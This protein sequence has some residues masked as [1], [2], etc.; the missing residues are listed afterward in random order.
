MRGIAD[1]P[2]ITAE[3]I[4]GVSTSVLYV[5][6]GDGQVYALNALTGAVIWHT[7]VATVSGQSFLWSSPSVYNGSVYEGTSSPCDVNVRGALVQLSATTGAIQNIFYV[8]PSG[9][10]GGGIWGSPTVDTATGTIYVATGDPSP[11]SQAE[12]YADAVLALRASDL[13][14]ISSWQ[15]PPAN[16][17]KDSDFGTTPTLFTATINGAVVPLLG[18]GNKDGIYYAFNSTA[19]GSGPIWQDQL[20][21]SGVNPTGGEGSI[22][23]SSFDGTT[24][25]VAGGAAMVGGVKCKGSAFALNPATGAELWAVCMATGSVVGAVTGVPGLVEVAGGHL[26]RLIGTAS[27]KTLFAYSDAATAGG[28]LQGAGTISHGMLYHADM[29]GTLYAIGT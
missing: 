26:L 25:Y 12:P 13:S 10:I 16:Q 22:S 20:W 18:V 24:L 21:P 5:G 4:G 3:N 6:G 9:C 8:V 17:F 7:P 11:C 14:L 23:P 29:H 1:A 27:G 2:T 28:A 15:V 19:I